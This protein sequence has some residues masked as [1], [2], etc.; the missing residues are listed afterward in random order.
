MLVVPS[1]FKGATINTKMRLDH[2]FFSS[3]ETRILKW[4]GYRTDSVRI[5]LCLFTSLI[6]INSAKFNQLKV[7]TCVNCD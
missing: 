6:I 1:Y 5:F 4:L 3:P 7:D 2:D